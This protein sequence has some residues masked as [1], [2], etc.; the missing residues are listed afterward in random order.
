LLPHH[1]LEFYSTVFL[2]F[3]TPWDLVAD[4]TNALAHCSIV[5]PFG[6]RL[7][8]R[9]CQYG[10]G[11]GGGPHDATARQAHFVHTVAAR[12]ML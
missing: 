5:L 7:P 11:R 10:G 3:L 8:D 9:L 4:G 2:V 6:A 1:W 12:R